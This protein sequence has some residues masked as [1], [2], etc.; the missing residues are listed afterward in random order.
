MFSITT[1]ALSTSRPS[2]TTN[3]TNE[4]LLI[5]IPVKCI[6]EADIKSDSG[7]TTAT[8]N[9]SFKPI[10]TNSTAIT[11]NKPPNALTITVLI[12]SATSSLSSEVM[13]TFKSLG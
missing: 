4:T 10:N 5:E 6:T 11:T 12:L 7:I 8:I 2:A 3:A 1:I 13:T 9:D